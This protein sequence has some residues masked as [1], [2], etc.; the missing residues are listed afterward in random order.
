LS[1]KLDDSKKEPSQVEELHEY[2]ISAFKGAFKKDYIP[3][4]GRDRKLLK[5]ALGGASFETLRLLIDRYFDPD[6]SYKGNCDVPSFYKAIN[7][8]QKD[9]VKHGRE[10][11][12]AERWAEK[13][14]INIWEDDGEGDSNSRGVVPK[15]EAKRGKH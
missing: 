12:V 9:G 5:Q 4:F 6:H 14:G 8:L 2:F 11:S 15:L 7:R 1:S 10:K 3:S 13:R